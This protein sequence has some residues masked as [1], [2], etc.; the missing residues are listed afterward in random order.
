MC[1]VDRFNTRPD[2]LT[3]AT[4]DTMR[5]PS[6]TNANYAMGWNVNANNIWWHLGSIHG[7]TSEI[8]RYGNAQVNFAILLN[9]RTQNVSDIS[10]AAD[11]LLWTVM[12]TIASWPAFDLFTG[13]EEIDKDNLFA[14]YPNPASSELNVYSLMFKTGDEVSIIDAVGKVVYRKT[15]GERNSILTISTEA[16]SNGIY[17][18]RIH[19]ATGDAIKKIII[20]KQN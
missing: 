6:V 17:F 19:T 3:T 14:I 5:K 13:V 8:I 2:I 20:Q 18:T 15:I 12:P 10:G 11:N 1:A 16:L 7:T 9:T 4:I